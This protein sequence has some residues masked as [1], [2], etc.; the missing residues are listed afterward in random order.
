MVRKGS[1]ASFH[2]L[3][4]IVL[5]KDVLVSDYLDSF[6]NYQGSSGLGPGVPS[7]IP[8][9]IVLLENPSG[10]AGQNVVDPIMQS[11]V[12]SAVLPVAGAL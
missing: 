7:P 1:Q 10:G 2:E 5:D 11:R 9:P 6:G 12:P 3:Y 4:S 8:R